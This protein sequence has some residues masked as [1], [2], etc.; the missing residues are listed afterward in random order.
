MVNDLG[1]SKALK[2][3]LYSVRNESEKMHTY[4][5]IGND[6]DVQW[7]LTPWLEIKIMLWGSSL[8]T[9]GRRKQ[10]QEPQGIQG[11]ASDEHS[12]RILFDH[13]LQAF[14]LTVLR[15]NPPQ[16]ARSKG[17]PICIRGCVDGCHAALGELSP[18]THHSVYKRTYSRKFPAYKL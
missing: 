4:L 1:V 12:I 16:S 17:F 3:C 5:L 14:C 10:G 7:T 6:D 15:H 9:R 11:T 18:S 13:N 2:I 8:A